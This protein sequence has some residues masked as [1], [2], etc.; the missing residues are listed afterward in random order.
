MNSSQC[1][2]QRPTTAIALALLVCFH[3][4]TAE[5][6]RRQT[7]QITSRPIAQGTI[8]TPSLQSVPVQSYGYDQSKRDEINKLIAGAKRIEIPQEFFKPLPKPAQE[9]KV[10]YIGGSAFLVTIDSGQVRQRL[11]QLAA[12]DPHVDVLWPG[13]ILRSDGLSTGTFAP[14]V[15]PRAPGVIVVTNP[16]STKGDAVYSAKITPAHSTVHN[17]IQGI[18]HQEMS[19]G[20]PA[21][22]SYNF[23]QFS[24]LTYMLRHFGMDVSFLGNSVGAKLNSERFQSQNNVAATLVQTYYTVDFEYPGDAAGFWVPGIRKAALEDRLGNHS[25][26]TAQLYDRLLTSPTSENEMTSDLEMMR[27]SP[28]E[29]LVR[30]QSGKTP[31]DAPVYVASVSY[32]RLLLL[33]AS[34]RQSI[35]KLKVGMEATANFIIGSATGSGGEETLKAMKESEL[36]VFALGGPG[37]GIVQLAAG[38]DKAKG[39]KDYLASGQDFSLQS[40][41]VPI[42]YTLRYVDDASLARLSFVTDYKLKTY[43]SDKVVAI[44]VSMQTTTQDKDRE[45]YFT[46]TVNEPDVGPVSKSKSYGRGDVWPNGT[47]KDFRLPILADKYV[48]RSRRLHHVLH[49]TYDSTSGDPD[50]WGRITAKA[51]YADGHLEDILSD[52]GPFQMGHYQGGN[53]ER[54]DRDFQFNQ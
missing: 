7:R 9:T 49:V 16:Q 3:S 43:D 23:R 25:T 30:D 44:H 20:T 40:G 11:D 2:R 42:S 50:W 22:V 17:A 5:A 38:D 13:A 33:I 26:M 28:T 48:P 24:D 15:F 41:G 31:L 53:P 21:K 1:C 27:R 46:F 36:T 12:L 10:E 32:G 37:S 39:L 47:R 29:A 8:A 52:T 18:L 14:I 34:G 4:S 19:P 6:K 35:D 54:K 51:E 45:I